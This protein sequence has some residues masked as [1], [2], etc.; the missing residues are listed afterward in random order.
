MR[1]FGMGHWMNMPEYLQLNY[2]N[3]AQPLE[4]MLGNK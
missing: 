3:L 2:G 4:N 1:S